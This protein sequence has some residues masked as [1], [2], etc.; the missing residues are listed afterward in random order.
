MKKNIG[1][2]SGMVFPISFYIATHMD[3][4]TYIDTQ[5][6][7]NCVVAHT[8]VATVGS[9]APIDMERGGSGGNAYCVIA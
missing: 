8:I 2:K 9:D 3:S 6:S 4:F 5:G 7:A 1:I